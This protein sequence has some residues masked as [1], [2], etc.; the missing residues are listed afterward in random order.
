MKPLLSRLD[1]F[2]TKSRGK[3]VLSALLFYAVTRIASMIAI[4]F[5]ARLYFLYGFDAMAQLRFAGSIEGLVYA[6]TEHGVWQMMAWL[7]LGA[8]LFEECA[9]R[10]G[11][12]FRRRHVAVGSGMLTVFVVSRFLPLWWAVPAGIAVAVAVWFAATDDCLTNLRERLLPAA[13]WLSAILFGVAHLFAMQ[14]LTLAVLP[15][16][17]MICLQLMFSGMTFVYLRVNLGFG[18]A[19]GAHILHNLPPA[20]MLSMLL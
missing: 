12:S 9:F 18:W 13:A 3:I 1:D 20:V 8:P 5:L 15:M 17:L 16:A 2:K 10:L 4:M 19:L 6:A 7:L 14:G 11:L